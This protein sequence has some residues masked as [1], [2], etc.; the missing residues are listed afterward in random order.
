[1]NAE[2]QARKDLRDQFAMS[3]ISSIVIEG[4]NI[5]FTHVELAYLIADAMLAVKD[6]RSNYETKNQL[7]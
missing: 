5:L 7:I 4:E 1:M 3:V 6:G 2:E